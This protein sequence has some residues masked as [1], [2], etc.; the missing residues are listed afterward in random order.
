MTVYTH[1]VREEDDPV[2]ANEVVELDLTRG[3][4]SLEVGGNRAK[5]ETRYPLLSTVSSEMSLDRWEVLT[6][7]AVPEPL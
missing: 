6:G 2:V 7:H 4:L 1:G 3:S 5:T